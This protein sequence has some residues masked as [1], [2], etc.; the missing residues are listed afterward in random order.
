MANLPPQEPNPLMSFFDGHDEI[1][2]WKE[3]DPMNQKLITCRDDQNI[4]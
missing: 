4:V 3:V 1:S 2:G